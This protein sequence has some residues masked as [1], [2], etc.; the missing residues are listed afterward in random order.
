VVFGLRIPLCGSVLL[1]GLVFAF[2]PPP[3]FSQEVTLKL[4]TG[5]LTFTGNLISFD[6]DNYVVETEALGQI[7]VSAEKFGC[8]GTGCP[9]AATTAA[10][11]T[12]ATTTAT[13]QL[14]GSTT[15]G[16]ELLPAII[17]KYAAAND[18]TVTRNDTDPTKFDLRLA[19][20]KGEPLVAFDFETQGTSNAFA[21]LASG[22]ADI[23]MASRPIN[24]KEIG[25]LAKAGFPDMNRPGREHVV[26]LDGIAIIVSARNNVGTLSVEDI[27]KAFSGEASD[28]SE[29]GGAPGKINIYTR[30]SDSATY[31]LFRDL[32]LKPF[33]R[34]IAPDAKLFESDVELAESVAKDDGGIGIV[35]LAEIGAAKPLSIKDTCG[36]FHDPTDFSVKSGEY[37]LSRNLYLYT[38]GAKN[39]FASEIVEFAVSDAVDEVVEKIGFITKGVRTV[40]FDRFRNHVAASLDAPPEDFDITLMRQLMKTLGSGQ[41]L[42]A[43]MRFVPSSSQLDSESVQALSRVVEFIGEQDLKTRKIVVAGYSDTTGLFEQNKELSLKRATAARDGMVLAAN[44]A[45]KPEDIE[46]QAYG[47]LMPVACNDTEA[48]RQKNRRVEI[49]LV[50]TEGPR[51]VVLTKQP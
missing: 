24:D 19:D 28:W 41:R 34:A 43:T 14:R 3:A 32:V 46:V 17:E 7:R 26:G 49:W 9:Q 6:G 35:T 33:K 39:K 11:V 8:Q 45:L 18:A 29:F 44:G 51:P 2:S 15:I 38:T 25:E 37:P 4:N 42:S 48:G 30:G 1:T 22:E 12:P 21:S 36:L 20:E 47:E 50:P 27:S 13:V 31:Q 16:L 5:G 23:G 10:V 40:S